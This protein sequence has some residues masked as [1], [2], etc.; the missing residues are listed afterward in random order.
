MNLG[1]NARTDARAGTEDSNALVASAV[2]GVADGE[3]GE[4]GEALVRVV[5][6]IRVQRTR[7]IE[8]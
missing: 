8:P 4:W 7:S 5:I 6:R 2:T 1:L 3:Q